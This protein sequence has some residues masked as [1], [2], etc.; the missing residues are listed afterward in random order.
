MVWNVLLLL[1]SPWY[2]LLGR[3]LRDDRDRQ[4]LLL[5]QQ[6]LIA[7]RRLGKR[8]CLRRGEK[9]ALVLGSLG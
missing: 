7:Q 5:H 1:F 3:L 6:L 9:L 8:P 4:I 2:L